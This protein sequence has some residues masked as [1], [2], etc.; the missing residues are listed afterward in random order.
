MPTNNEQLISSIAAFTEKKNIDQHTVILMLKEVLENLIVRKFGPDHHIDVIID[1]KKGDLQIWRTKLIV[2]DEEKD[3]VD[4]STISLS[5]ALKIEKDFEVGEDFTE[6]IDISTF[7][8]R[9]VINGM[10]LLISKKRALETNQLYQRYKKLENTLISA[11][12]GYISHKYTILYHGEEKTELIL[13]KNHQIPNE[14]FRKGDHIKALVDKVLLTENNR[15]QILLTRTSPNFLREL[16][17]LEVPEVLD[18]VVTIKD[19]VRIP[20]VRSKVIVESSDDRIDPAGAC[21]GPGGRRVQSIS[22][23]HLDGE[24]IDVIPY[25]DDLLLYIKRI[26]GMDQ[27]PSLRAN[28]NTIILYAKPD[29][30]GWLMKNIFFLKKILKKEVHI[31]HS[32]LQANEDVF[33]DEF[34]NEI[35]PEVIARIKKAGFITAQSVLKTSQNLFIEKTALEATLVDTIYA[36]LT[37]E[38]ES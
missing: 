1:E 37:K 17:H 15:A 24:R 12:I 23:T 7:S 32:R 22:K 29:Q 25:T 21:I 26:T 28:D 30:F 11:E 33:L 20:G 31:L 38:F 5:E 14:R 36:I 16:L 9:A 13:H 35:A 19:I 3:P 6:T 10:R 34:A 18:R 27:S 4:E 8:R 2:A